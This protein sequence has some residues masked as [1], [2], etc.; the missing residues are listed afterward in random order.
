MVPF[1]HGVSEAEA[2]GEKWY[3]VT[4]WE[5]GRTMVVKAEEAVMK[6]EEGR[7]RRM[8]EDGGQ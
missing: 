7:K 4:G 2:V 8:K 3:V 6:S 1:F 5:G